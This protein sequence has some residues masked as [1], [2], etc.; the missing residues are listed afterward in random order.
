[1]SALISQAN[2]YPSFV[3]DPFARVIFFFFPAEGGAKKRGIEELTKLLTDKAGGGR[4]NLPES[5]GLQ[6][7]GLCKANLTLY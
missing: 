7:V 3:A 4:G 2:R 6:A 1:M 5:K